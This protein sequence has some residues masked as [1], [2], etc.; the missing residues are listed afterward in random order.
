[1]LKL[2]I[3]FNIVSKNKKYVIFSIIPILF[4]IQNNSSELRLVRKINQ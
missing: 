1:M 4:I 3:F 2:M